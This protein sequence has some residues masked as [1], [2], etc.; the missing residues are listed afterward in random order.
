MATQPMTNLGGMEMKAAR[1]GRYA[2][3][4]RRHGI[5]CPPARLHAQLNHHRLKVRGNTELGAAG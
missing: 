4:A 2:W 5:G 3:L 1:C